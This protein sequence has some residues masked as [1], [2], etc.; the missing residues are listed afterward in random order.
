MP[1]KVNTD[2]FIVFRVCISSRDNDSASHWIF[3]R[4]DHMSYAYILNSGECNKSNHVS[5][6]QLQRD[7]H[8]RQLTKIYTFNEL[9]SEFPELI[10]I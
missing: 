4:D 1:K 7:Q 10:N 5:I 8:W 9:I 3:K 2:E 6:Y